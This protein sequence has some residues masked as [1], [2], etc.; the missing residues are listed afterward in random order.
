MNWPFQIIPQ[1]QVPVDAG[2]VARGGV[3]PPRYFASGYYQP[4]HVYIA[5]VGA[6]T[7]TTAAGNIYYLPIY[8]W[9]TQTF[10][11]MSNITALA[12]LNLGKQALLGVYNDDSTS[13]GPGTLRHTF[14]LVTFSTISAVNTALNSVTLTPSRYWMTQ[15]F[16]TS[17]DMQRWLSVAPAS[18]N[19]ISADIGTTDPLNLGI[20]PLVPVGW[21]ATAAF[22]STFPASAAVPSAPLVGAS[23]ALATT[24]PQCYLFV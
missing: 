3:N 10:R 17:V 11:G 4:D 1:A 15:W 20:S 19:N 13:G 18:G 14:G 7:A 12:T 9:Q 16:A 21:F 6:A 22:A 23:S 24:C 2:S 5:A 8:V